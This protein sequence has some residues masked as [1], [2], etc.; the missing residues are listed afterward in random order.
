MI[1]NILII[2]VTI[3]I[4]T[5]CILILAPK[6]TINTDKRTKLTLPPLNY[7]IAN[8][9][10]IN[11]TGLNKDFNIFFHFLNNNAKYGCKFIS[12]S[13]YIQQDQKALVFEHLLKFDNGIEIIFIPNQEL[14][15]DED[16]DF[17]KHDNNVVTVLCKSDYALEIF[18]NFKRKHKCSW[19]LRRLKFPSINNNIAINFEKDRNIFCHPAGSSWMKNTSVLVETWKQH[20]EWPTLVLSCNKRCRKIHKVT[21]RNVKAHKNIVYIPFFNSYELK[22][23]QM[24]AGYIIMPSACEGFGHSIFEAMSNGNLLIS[25]D[26]P[27]MNEIVNYKN[28]L[29]I[30]KDKE[31]MVGSTSDN[32]GEWIKER[33]SE[34]GQNGSKC[35][36]ISVNDIEQSVNDAINLSDDEYNDLR[37]NAYNTWLNNFEQGYNNVKEE[38]I[39]HNF[40]CD[41]DL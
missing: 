4:L 35:Y 39:K 6:F 25:I 16:V 24:H 28:A 13:H 1:T 15:T 30:K 40:N 36:S 5:L 2:S 27:P 9:R 32:L 14:I 23:L 37:T 3:I 19:Q 20:P 18:N 26:A 31:Y 17:L 10:K 34:M 12:H 11:N 29:L 8:K 7:N 33:S 41:S 22:K 38:L 21:K